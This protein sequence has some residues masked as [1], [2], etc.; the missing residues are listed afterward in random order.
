MTIQEIAQRLTDLCAKQDF[1]TAQKELFAENAISIEPEAMGPFEKETRGLPGIFKKGELFGDMV[2]AS[3][4]CKVSK[5]IIAGNA[6]AFTLSMDVKMKDR[7][8]STMDEIC[9]YVVK[10]GKIISEQFFW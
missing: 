4:G 7:D 1:H 10:D 6:I 9:V 5:P 2:E 8:R 3:Y